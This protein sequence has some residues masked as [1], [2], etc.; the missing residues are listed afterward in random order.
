MWLRYRLAP[1]MRPAYYFKQ[2][3][4]KQL[5]LTTVTVFDPLHLGLRYDQERKRNDQKNCMDELNDVRI[6]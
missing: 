3:I 1:E 6:L 2:E 5:V 4:L